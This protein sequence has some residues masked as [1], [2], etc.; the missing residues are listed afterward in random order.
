[1]DFD[2]G[3][4]LSHF[5]I[6][7]ALKPTTINP[8]TTLNLLLRSNCQPEQYINMR[9]IFY[10]TLLLSLLN[11]TVATSSRQLKLFRRDICSSNGEIDCDTNCMPVGSVCCNDGSGTYCP[12]GD[13][14]VPDGCC[15]I[16]EQ[17]SGGG[18]TLTVNDLTGTDSFPTSTGN[19]VYKSTTPTFYSTTPTFESTTRTFQSYSAT[20][21]P[22]ATNTVTRSTVASTP[23]T[24][25]VTQASG[26]ALGRAS[27][28]FELHLIA[29]IAAGFFMLG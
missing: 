15:P 3:E 23:S 13:R 8:R 19:S 29:G 22:T 9:T 5:S 20:A 7:L 16:G 11:L 1:M 10:T 26:A 24:T 27:H 17:C 6:Y 12:S 14:C 2:P 25:P 28:S 21:Q 18:G 4:F